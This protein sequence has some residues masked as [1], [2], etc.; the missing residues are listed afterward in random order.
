[1]YRNLTKLSFAG[2]VAVAL[3]AFGITSISAPAWAGKV[4]TCADGNTSACILDALDEYLAQQVKTV[5]A[6]SSLHNGNLG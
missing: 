4:K 6:S 1:M 5:F 3:L 2:V